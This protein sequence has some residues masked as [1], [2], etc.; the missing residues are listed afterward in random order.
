MQSTAEWVSYNPT[1]TG[2][3]NFSALDTIEQCRGNGRLTFK[4]IWPL[5]AGGNHQ[6]WS[7]TSNPLLSHPV[8]G[9]RPIDAPYSE[10]GWGGLERQ[11]GGPSLLDGTV[12][13]DNWH[14]RR[15]QHRGGP[16]GSVEPPG[17]LPMHL[18]TVYME[19][20]ECLPTILNPLA[21]RTR[22]SFPLLH[23]IFSYCVEFF[24]ASCMREPI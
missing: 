10:N 19:C 16:G 12:N 24:M 20:S 11:P 14:Y 3:P 2:A 6:E 17:P 7:Q 23:R 4:L 21:E 5:K 8:E 22:F 13:H 9:Y 18:H 1:D 15:E